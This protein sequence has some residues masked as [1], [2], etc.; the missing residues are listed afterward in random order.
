[1]EPAANNRTPAAEGV[2]TASQGTSGRAADR[3]AETKTDS[4][5]RWVALALA[6]LGQGIDSATSAWVAP[7]APFLQSDL[8]IT[9]AELGGIHSSMRLGSVMA[10]LLGGH[11][12]DCFGIRLCLSASLAVAGT[13][14][15]ITAGI[16]WYW[17]ILVAG[18][19]LG[20]AHGPANPAVTKA[21]AQWFPP[22]SRGT[23]M[24]IKQAGFPLT[25]AAMAAL[26]PAIAETS[27]WRP[28]LAG[29]GIVIIGVAILAYLAYREHPAG[30][31][32][33]ARLVSLR[34]S[35]R[36]LLSRDLLALGTMA[37]CFTGV[38]MASMTYL[39]LYMNEFQ[40]LPVVEAGFLLSAAYAGG[41]VG[42]IGWGVI[43]DWV[44][45]GRRKHT[46]FLVS[47]ISIANLAFLALAGPGLPVPILWL[48]AFMV[49]ITALGWNG[50]YFAFI[51]ELAGSATAAT[52]V[53]FSMTLQQIGNLLAPPIFGM[54]VD[55]SGAYRWAWLFLVALAGAGTTCI[56][57]IRERAQNA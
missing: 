44:F 16:P 42:R 10:M 31:G 33:Q 17:G 25:G 6:V 15:I 50:V 41:V 52:A 51:V 26:L 56:S 45:G 20:V 19:C 24:S 22:R 13:L 30:E 28:I 49:G 46:L 34:D 8:N 32:P 36:H 12:V 38:Q 43:S 54:V 35:G 40:G 29:V 4:R 57:I 5:Y 14:V 39:V 23:A 37:S 11:L 55:M 3:L 53:G 18:V 48:L 21:V 1:M 27:G 9:R 2:A 47:A 7:L